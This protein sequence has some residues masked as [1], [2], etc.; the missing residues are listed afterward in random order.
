MKKGELYEIH[1]CDIISDNTKWHTEH[2]MGDYLREKP[3]IFVNIAYY[4]GKN[5]TYYLF[6]SG[7][8]ALGDYFDATRI[9]IKCIKKI[10]KK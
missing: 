3:P 5:R 1:W 4:F 6:Y 10:I 9:P 8:S 2:D 7:Y